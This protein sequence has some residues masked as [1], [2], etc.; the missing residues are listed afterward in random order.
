MPGSYL[1]NLSGDRRHKIERLRIGG[2]I[3]DEI[4]RGQ[5]SSTEAVVPSCPP[6]ATRLAVTFTPGLIKALGFGAHRRSAKPRRSGASGGDRKEQDHNLRSKNGRLWRS[7][8]HPRASRWRS[9]LPKGRDGRIAVLS[10]VDLRWTWRTRR[11]NA[12]R[13]LLGRVLIK[14]RLETAS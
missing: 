6:R 5:L 2:R 3:D 13:N 11:R 12:P 10:G 7:S 14:S 8:G 4:A 9:R 1:S